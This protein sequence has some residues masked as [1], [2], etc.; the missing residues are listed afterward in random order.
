MRGGQETVT[1]A[2]KS[3]GRRLPSEDPAPGFKWA[4]F[5]GGHPESP[6]LRAGRCPLTSGALRGQP[7]DRMPKAPTCFKLRFSRE[8]QGASRGVCIAKS[9]NPFF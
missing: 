9:Y 3:P 1:I 6:L 8:T 4:G 5:G 7:G 2:L